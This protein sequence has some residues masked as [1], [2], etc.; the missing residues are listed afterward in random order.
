MTYKIMIVDDEPANLR[1]LERLFRTDYQVVTAPSGAEAL[2]LLEQHD[3]AARLRRADLRV[4]ALDDAASVQLAPG[5]P[6]AFGFP[7]GGAAEVPAD[8]IPDIEERRGAV[9]VAD[10]RQ[11]D[12]AHRR[13]I[14]IIRTAHNLRAASHAW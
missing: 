8:L 10:H 3:V 9:E 6:G 11:R 13:W 4:D 12:V 2:V 14:T 1:T 7:V 5:E